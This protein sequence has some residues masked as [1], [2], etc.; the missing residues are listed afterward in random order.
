MAIKLLVLGDSKEKYF[1]DSEA[2]Y[3]KRLRRYVKLNYIT[4]AASKKYTQKKDVLQF[5]EDVLL[6]Q[7]SVD[8]LLILLDE[9]GEEFTSRKFADN[10]NK[11]MYSPGNL[12]FAI[13]GAFGFSEK[14]KQRANKQV[15]LSKLTFPHHLVRTL[16]LEQL[17]RAFTILKGEKYHND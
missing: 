5:E 13:G 9:H 12:V 8:D 6:K 10:L 4:L 3:V 17:Y 2:E 1:K 11:W 7:I 16:F 15:S 14:V